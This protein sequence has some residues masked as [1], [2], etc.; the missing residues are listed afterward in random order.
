[1]LLPNFAASFLRQAVIFWHLNRVRVS[2][3]PS[4]IVSVGSVFQL[5]HDNIFLVILIR[6]CIILRGMY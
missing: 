2:R 6:T 1:M 4:A 3:C 5:D